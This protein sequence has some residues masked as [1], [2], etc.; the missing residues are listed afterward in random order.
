MVC[1]D[2]R[3]DGQ[4]ESVAIYQ[5]RKVSGICFYLKMTF[6][7][8]MLGCQIGTHIQEKIDWMGKIGDIVTGT[9]C[10]TEKGENWIRGDLHRI[11][12]VW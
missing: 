9:I 4:S 8:K 3:T 10:M 6:P 7:G 5:T 12:N 11:G 1:V 2:G